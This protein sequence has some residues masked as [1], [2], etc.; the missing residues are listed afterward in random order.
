MTIKKI[1]AVVLIFSLALANVSLVFASEYVQ[2]FTADEFYAIARKAETDSSNCIISNYAELVQCTINDEKITSSILKYKNGDYK[3]ESGQDIFIS[4]SGDNLW[5]HDGK[6]VFCQLKDGL[7]FIDKLIK[8]FTDW[9][10]NAAKT[11]SKY[12]TL[13]RRQVFSK[14]TEI[15]KNSSS[16]WI[17][18][19]IIGGILW[20]G[21][22]IY[23]NYLLISKQGNRP[24]KG[25][26][27]NSQTINPIS[28][29][30]IVSTE[31][32][33]TTDSDKIDAGFSKEKKAQTDQQQAESLSENEKAQ[34]DQQIAVPAP[35]Y[36]KD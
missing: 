7:V 15:T 6:L 32:I 17:Y 24:Q 4:D 30:N 8:F 14:P 1:F 31:D 18:V 3:Y 19:P 34:T 27:N 5:I 33:A 26:S 11:L 12:K 23:K 36:A 9:D 10:V 2:K 35:D 16:R 28:I 13:T 22:L 29:N 21:N 25:N 20:L